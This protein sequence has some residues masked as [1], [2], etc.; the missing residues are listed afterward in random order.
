MT[1]VDTL[2]VQDESRYQNGRETGSMQVRR[3]SNIER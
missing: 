2:Q 3:E 1:A